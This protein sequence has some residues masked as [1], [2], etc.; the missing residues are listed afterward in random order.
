VFLV[1]HD[2]AVPGIGNLA[3][4]PAAAFAN[5]RLANGEPLPTLE[6][7]LAALPGLEA[8]IEVKHLPEQWDARFLEVLDRA[9]DP[10]RCGV[11][12]FDHRIIARLGKRQAGLRRGVLLC[13]YLLDPIAAIRATGAGTLWQEAHLIDRGLVTALHAAGLE[14]VAWTV[15]DDARARELAQVGVDGLCGNFPDQL[16]AAVG[17]RTTPA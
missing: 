10:A 5:H 15:N 1:H 2:P 8:W 14:V 16:L 13:S 7:A 4:L 17:Q 11:H 6:Q 9:P 3:D 12:G